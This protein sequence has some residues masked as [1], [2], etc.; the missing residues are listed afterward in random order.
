MTDDDQQALPDF[1][2]DRTDRDRY[3]VESEPRPH[4]DGKRIRIHIRNG[5]P[6]MV[7]VLRLVRA[8]NADGWRLDK[9]SDHGDELVFVP[10]EG[11]GDQ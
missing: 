4:H 1:A 6:A 5:A 9:Y 2:A 3:T 8:A 11:G 7:T 10:G